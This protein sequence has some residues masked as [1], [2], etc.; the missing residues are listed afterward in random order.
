M[1]TP[2]RKVHEP[3]QEPRQHDLEARAKER[4]RRT[5]RLEWS[6]IQWG[7]RQGEISRMIEL[8]KD[9]LV[10]TQTEL[11]QLERE[12]GYPIDRDKERD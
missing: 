12:L 9:A 8:L 2:A 1:M 6:L 5:R 7:E 4:Y 11:A 3:K 10:V